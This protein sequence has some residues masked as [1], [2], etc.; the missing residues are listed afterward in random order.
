M[1][2][3]AKV[4]TCL[5]FEQHGAE[6]AAFYCTLLPDSE[7]TGHFG[8]TPDGEPLVVDFTLGGAPYQI[9]TGGPYQKQTEAVSISVM[10]EDQ[11]ETD[12]L[13]TALIADG[14]AESECGWLK[15]RWSVSWQIVPQQLMACL[16]GPDAAG[17]KRATDA[18][19]TM[20]KID[21]AAIE[22]AYKGQ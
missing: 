15:D 20:K 14:G 5:W 19:F 8:Q 7:V 18:M 21:I 6:A 1:S 12:R 2:A 4:R 16:G 3:T 17:A 13:W 10:T 22:A 11:A 9:L